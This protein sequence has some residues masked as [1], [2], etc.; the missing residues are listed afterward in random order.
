MQKIVSRNNSLNTV[1]PQLLSEWDYA[2]N[3]TL[4][5]ENVAA[6]SNTK[7][8]WKCEKGH[9][10]QASL[11]NRS[12]GTNCPICS[13]RVIL[14]GYNDLATVSPDLLRE[15][16]FENNKDIDPTKVGSGSTKDAWWIC[17]KGHRWKTKIV[18][19][20]GNK[21]CPF[22]ANQKVLEGYNDLATTH[23]YLLEEWDY[24]KNDIKPT[25][26]LAGSDRKVWWCCKKC[27]YHWQ[28]SLSHRKK[29]RGCPKCAGKNVQ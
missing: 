3:G 23:S 21:G 20:R 14:A 9:E 2:K 12:K 29:G 13:N 10:W 4:I 15:W 7:V 27:S 19:R 28:A 6:H 24:Q 25:E 16:D 17:S 26:V 22:C 8:W 11:N 1:F 18:N 5:P